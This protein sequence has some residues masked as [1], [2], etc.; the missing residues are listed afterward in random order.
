LRALTAAFCS[1]LFLLAATSLGCEAVGACYGYSDIL[2]STYCYDDWYDWECDE[3]AA[4][5]VNGASWSF[6]AGQTCADL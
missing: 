3:Y 2:D 6:Y 5:G 1:L 4:E